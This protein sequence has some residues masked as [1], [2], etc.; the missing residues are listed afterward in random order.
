MKKIFTLLAGVL[1]AIGAQAQ[2]TYNLG[3]L[4]IADFTLGDAF[5]D[6]GTW[7][8]DSGTYGGAEGQAYPCISYTKKDKDNWSDL[9][10]NGTPIIFQYKN[11]GAKDKFYRLF[12]N[13]FY[14]NGKPSRITVTG[15]T[16]GQVV[17]FLAA[18]K[19]S[20]GCMFSEVENCSPDE[21]NPTDPVG[22]EMDPAN[23]T[24]FKFTALADGS[25][26]VAETNAGFH[27]ASITIED[28]SGTVTPVDPTAPTHWDFTVTSDADKAALA[29][30]TDNWTYSES[31]NRYSNAVDFE[32]DTDYEL[33]AGNSILE[34]F[35]GLVVGRDGGSIAAGNVRIDVD[36]RF[37]INASN[38][39]IKLLNMAKDDII[40]IHFAS[41]STS[42][43]ARTLTINNG[44]ADDPSTLTSSLNTDEKIAKIT[45]SANGDVK[46]TQ[47][48]GVNFYQ[49]FVNT[50]DMPTNIN[51]TL[52]DKREM[53]NDKVIY[54]LAGRRV[55]ANY[56]GVVIMNGK[57][58]VNK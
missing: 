48:K 54:D 37:Q 2:T 31:N 29:A 7:T 58:V 14:S 22:K 42:E 51:A 24:A 13:F 30:D 28:G 12:P 6:G 49:I 33:I 32:K 25:I 3:G 41:A 52:N 55:D 44:V 39:Y 20:D 43:E 26:T 8:D 46:I 36:K 40:Y 9:V 15:L 18:G 19:N 38:G 4:Q 50:D 11:S 1:L 56:H 35:A 5:E 23:F 17:T 34:G 21:G 47:S 10:L 57:K 27:L 45:V 16:A 53:T